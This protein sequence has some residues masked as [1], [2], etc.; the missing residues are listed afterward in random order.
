MGFLNSLDP[1]ERQA[2]ISVA[3]D[4][5]F[6]R[7]AR[8]ME[9]GEPANYVIVILSGWTRI[10]VPD[11]DGE[12][13][14]AERGPGQLVG[15]RGALRVDVRSATVIALGTVRALVMRTE[16]FASFIDV[17][18]RVL[19]ILE[20]QVYARLTEESMGSRRVDLSTSF[21]VEPAHVPIDSPRR[22]QLAGENCTVLLTDVVEFGALNRNDQDRQIVRLSSRDML[23][24]SL[25]R[26][27]DNCITE[28]RGDGLLII[29]PPHIPT[30]R[31]MAPLN[32]ELPGALRR[33]NHTYSDSVRIRLRVA[34]NVGPVM[35]DDFGMS[36]EAIIRTARLIDAPAFKEAMKASG[37][38]LGIITSEFVY[39]TA[40]RHAA[41]LINVN[42]YRSVDVNV[43]E[44]SIPGWMRLVDPSLP[45]PR[46]RDPLRAPVRYAGVVREFEL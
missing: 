7:G 42:E 36:G 14:I 2:F 19:D 30:V 44:S 8:I 15:E 18:P 29:V 34:A 21:P 6:V 43:K 41:E 9:E 38:D 1:A 23:R 27:W 10:I 25:G 32:Q 5:T 13:V 46:L 4:R 33:H 31:V 26:V 17:H 22:R 3:H 40:I 16:D 12:R 20:K 11:D 28:D 24:A 45:E 35:S 39:E 37:A